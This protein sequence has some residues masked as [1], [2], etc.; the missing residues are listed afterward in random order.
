MALS[1]AALT[2]TI[3]FA[4]VAAGAFLGNQRQ[5]FASVVEPG[6]GSRIT[7][8]VFT[9]LDAQGNPI[10]HLLPDG[11]SKT[12]PPG[13]GTLTVL[14]QV[15]GGSAAP[16]N[17]SIHVLSNSADISGSPQAGSA[18]GTTYTG[19]PPGSYTV[20]E[21]GG[22][23]NYTP[24]FSG[25][26]NSSGV[27]TIAVGDIV[28]CTI[29][30]TFSAPTNPENTLAL[31]GDGLDNDG[32]GKIDLADPDCA[33]FAPKL[34][35][36]KH[37]A[38]GDGTFSFSLSG[39]TVDT[40]S[41]TTTSG[42]ATSSAISLGVGETVLA[43]TAASGWTLSALQCSAT[44]ASIFASPAEGARI[45]AHIG[46]S[47]MCTF[48]N[49]AQIAEAAQCSD[50]I[51]NDEDGMTDAADPSCHSD[52]NASNAASFDPALDN[53][54]AQGASQCSDGHDNDNDG[55]TDASD[56]GCHGDFNASNASTYDPTRN[57]ESAAQ[58]LGGGGGSSGQSGGGTGGGTIVGL[59]TT[60]VAPTVATTTA[61]STTATSTSQLSV[62]GEVLGISTSTPESCDR[63]LTAYI[64]A[65]QENDSM[66]VKR[67]QV[68]LH[69]F[70]GAK[71]DVNG[72]YD[73]ATL[74]AVHAF[75]QKYGSEIL[76]PWGLSRSTGF[77]YY[78][79]RKKINE[80]YCKGT[81][82]FPLTDAQ[83]KE[84]ARYRSSQGVSPRV[85]IAEIASSS[86]PA[87]A[88]A[89]AATST[90]LPVP[91]FSTTTPDSSQKAAPPSAQDNRALWDFVGRLRSALPW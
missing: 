82:Q 72:V 78:T 80:I 29:S 55:K 42:A 5:V 46:D 11:C 20:S 75:Q 79:T 56:P 89:R 67:L 24:T 63:F 1:R 9:W 65:G 18:S 23:A 76:T 4:I 37:T 45:T 22:P 21:T 2:T 71:I 47:V 66:Q 50:G 8:S 87:S 17:F 3:V 40:R 49:T 52:F 84:I 62:S 85:G 25:A 53:E 73:G 74:A 48:T 61:T 14:K 59:I 28:T 43:E 32:D 77:V 68:V 58:S 30:N 31:C 15:F 51:D 19:F 13:G 12:P 27:V 54:A 10:P 16:E 38:G 26:C 7:C 36:V 57:D 88:P 64:K 90:V 70:E 81:M 34:T 44:G 39:A 6:L 83:L 86:A 33:D 91:S 35:I 41:L 60:A 69:D